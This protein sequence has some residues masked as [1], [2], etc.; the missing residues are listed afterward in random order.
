MGDENMKK[1]LFIGGD[2][3]MEYAADYISGAYH[4]DRL[5][6]GDMPEGRYEY[7]VLPLPV[8]RDGAHI[9]APFAEKPL[10]FG[11]IS[12]YAAE[13][14]V[15]FCGGANEAV[16]AICRGMGL[17]FINYFADE[18][19]TLKNAVLTAESAAAI[20]AG[21]NDSSLFGS[22]AAITGGG[23]VAV[24]TA[25]LLKAFGASVTLCARSAEQRTRAELD[26]FSTADIG[27]L[28][29]VCGRA[30]FIINTVPAEL[31]DEGVFPAMKRG[32]VYLELAS[33]PPEPYKSR[34]EKHGV[35]YIHAPGLPGKYS[36]KTAG[37][38]IAETIL[39]ETDKPDK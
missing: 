39:A 26:G 33:L 2:K 6:G 20:L 5:N 7:I 17:K 13:N 24:Y 28:P 30:D 23:R 1:F 34:S 36:P 25:R 15:V 10:P 16:E 29:A 8:S 14:A 9:N 35:K 3:R 12:Q 32:A 37:E 11:L 31:F 19:H 22:M 27:E 38:I 4:V 18:P 21:C